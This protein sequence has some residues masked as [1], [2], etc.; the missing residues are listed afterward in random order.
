M[1]K[2]FSRRRVILYLLLYTLI[3]FYTL[4]FPTRVSWFLFYAFTLLLAL[5]YISSRSTAVISRVT[6]T[7]SQTNQ[8]TVHITLRSKNWLPLFWPTLSV[9]LSKQ[10]H[11]REISQ[12]V[13]IKKA[14]P[15]S[16]QPIRLGRG[17][18][19]AID[20]SIEATGLFGLYSRW[21]TQSLPIDV[22]VYPAVMTKTDRASLMKD[23]STLL[24]QSTYSSL[25]EF[26]VKEIRNY[27]NRDSLSAIDWKSSM[28]RG[29]WMVKDYE[30]EEEAPF[31]VIFYGYQSSQF[32]ELLSVAYN[33]YLEL[34]SLAS[35]DLLLLGSF[36]GVPSF[37]T[38]TA[39]FLPVEAASD[40]ERLSILFNDR[41]PLT[42]RLFII[43]PD[44]RLIPT[45]TILTSQYFIID[46][47][48]LNSLKGV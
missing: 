28:R 11:L 5:A 48:R 15:F 17:H 38:T 39:S 9:T 32:E 4:T 44:S 10:G 2:H 46:E 27:Q 23:L 31:A 47:S 3:I 43:T 41:V 45:H 20:L 34:H 37:G 35:C 26:Y 36:K 42:K 8:L 21:F 33:L 14:V 6:A 30:K 16:F 19:R 18:H 40:K 29:Q 12:S 13:L 25:H 1:I 22:D 24:S 7:L